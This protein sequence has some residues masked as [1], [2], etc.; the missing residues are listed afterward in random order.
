MMDALAEKFRACDA[1]RRHFANEAATRLIYSKHLRSGDVVFDC[2]AN[3][4]EHTRVLA[5]VVGAAGLV[6]AFEPNP[7]HFAR[8][9]ALG[10]NVRLWPFAVGDRLSIETLHIPAGMSGWA[11]LRDTRQVLSDKAF[12]LRTVIQVRIDDLPEATERMVRFAKVDVEWREL[13]ALRG[14][15]KLLQRDRP[16][17]VL[18]TGTA[19]ISAL[20]AS[21]GYDLQDLFGRP[22]VPRRSALA[23]SVAFPREQSTNIEQSL[24][25]VPELERLFGYRNYRSPRRYR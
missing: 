21:I 1:R 19:P 2:G 7:A 13:Q 23:N 3:I 9:L 17:V 25:T 12:T 24:P 15:L 6:H 8:L 20:F 11:S 10:A 22:L 4:G 5:R 16:L 18:E 14:M